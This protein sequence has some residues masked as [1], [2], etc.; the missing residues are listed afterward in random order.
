MKQQAHLSSSGIHPKVFQR[1]S[2]QFDPPRKTS[3]L[4][5]EKDLPA[6]KAPPLFKQVTT[7][8]L[9]EHSN[10]VLI[11]S[12]HS[13]SDSSTDTLDLINVEAEETM[14]GYIK[15]DEAEEASNGCTKQHFWSIFQAVFLLAVLLLNLTYQEEP[16]G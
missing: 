7:T 13:P 14:D 5:K 9:E 2:T 12:Y 6:R 4:C 15:N 16:P 3:I 11:E 8:P 1:S 10:V